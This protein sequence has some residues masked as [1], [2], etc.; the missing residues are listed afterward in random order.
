MV[1][2]IR[3]RVWARSSSVSLPFWTALSSELSI[4]LRTPED[5]LVAALGADLDDAARHGAGADDADL[6]DG[7]RP[8]GRG[9]CR[10][11]GVGHDLG[12]VG[13]GVGVEPT[14]GLTAEQPR[15]DVLLEQGRRRVPVVARLRVHRLEDL[16]RRVEA[17]Q[18]EQGQRA[19][20]VTAAEAHGRVDVLAGGVLALVH[21][22][23]V[24]EVAEQQRVGDEAGPVTG[25]GGLLADL[26]DELLDRLDDRRVGDDRLDDLDQ[27]HHG[28]RVEPVQADDLRRPAGARRQLGHR[29]RG[30]VGGQHRLRR[31]QGVEAGE[32][33]LLE[34]HPLRDGLDHQAAVL[35]RVEVG[36]DRDAAEQRRLLVLGELAAADRP[37][38]RGG[39]VRLRALRARVV[40]LHAD[41][42]DAR[43]GEDLCDTGTHGAQPD[44]TD[45]AEGHDHSS[46]RG[47]RCA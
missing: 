43:A 19:H 40:L 11:V 16:V 44:D 14:P 38:G 23:G 13:S 39:Q 41:D 31:Q 35:H 3:S 42:L 7:A 37:P 10:G 2:V 33:V 25:G 29:Q 12:G 4:F 30:G 20:R 36:A 17:D 21:L 15:G 26:P 22:H 9:G 45:L 28:S 46:R 5:D 1:P 32:Q 8:G 18:V 27:A 47:K 34:L 6:A 24:V